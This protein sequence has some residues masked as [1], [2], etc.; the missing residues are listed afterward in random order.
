MRDYQVRG[1]NCLKQCLMYFHLS[2][3]YIANLFYEYFSLFCLDIA[4]GT[5]RDYQVR[6]LNWLISL[7]ESG[8]NGILADEMG[9]GKTLQ[10]IS[11]LG[12]MKHIK[13]VPSPHLVIVPKSTLANW[14]AEFAR[15]CPSLRAVS[16]MGDKDSRVSPIITQMHHT[17]PHT[18]TH[19][20]THIHMV[21]NNLF[22]VCE[23]T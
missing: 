12:F 11:L 19:T 22:S 21:V 18:N 16:L 15:W 5:M 3:L 7:Y 8:I 23:Q 1:L 13:N 14:V 2:I 4:N 10:T 9:L 6:G 17:Q 20:P